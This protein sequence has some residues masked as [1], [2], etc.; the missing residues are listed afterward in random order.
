[1]KDSFFTRLLMGVIEM[2][3][4]EMAS[5]AVRWGATEIGMGY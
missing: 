3:Y 1:V 2:F 5:Q 4:S